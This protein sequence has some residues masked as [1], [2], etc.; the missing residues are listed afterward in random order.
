VAALGPAALLVVLLL[1]PAP[2]LADDTL[3]TFDD[4]RIVESS[5]LVDLG[6]LMVTTN[7]S[8]DTGRVFTVDPATGETM[9]VTT[10]DAE[11]VDVEALAPAGRRAVWVGDIGD[12]SA[13][14][15][16]VTV[17]RVPVARRDLEVPSPV[18]YRLRY[19]DGAH[20]A[21][22]LLATRSG[23]LYVI[24][25]TFSGGTV[26]R[27]PKPLLRS[28]TN[29]LKAVAEVDDFATDAALMRGE[30]F[31]L[32]RGP[33]Q[34]TVYTF[35]D[36]ERVGTFPLPRQQQGEGVSVGPRN[37]V[38]IST[39]GVHTA[40]KQVALPTTI[41]RVLQKSAPVAATTTTSPP[42]VEP[43]AGEQ[44]S[45]STWLAWSLAGAAVLAAAGVALARSRRSA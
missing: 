29:R 18:S 2:V 27:A 4:P 28:G 31:A 15:D 22:S 5:G 16:E 19:P 25:K 12:N 1:R 24:T 39:E 32:V 3:L 23:R 38:R 21:E 34:A 43:D 41:A 44:E 42:A 26:Y 20:D 6:P 10:F 11:V 9:G 36:F 45:P 37:R 8:G 35:P 14:R 7:D 40:V 17:H 33:G 13:T 30:R